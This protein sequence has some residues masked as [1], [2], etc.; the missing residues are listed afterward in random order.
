MVVEALMSIPTIQTSRL[1]LRAF[2]GADAAPLHQIMGEPGVLR[3]FPNQEPPSMDRVARMVASQLAHWQEHG[4]GWWAVQ[5]RAETGLIGWAGLQ[6]LPETDETE[7]AYLLAK[8]YWGQGL[9]TEAARA[10]LDFAF[11]GL[12][13]EQIVGIVHPE[14]AASQGVLEKLGMTLV[15]RTQ[16]FGM[17]CLRYEISKVVTPE[18]A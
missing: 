1:V 17:D 18:S 2:T 12:G 15:E 9:A 13:L 16:Y 3:Y 11:D 8:A 6:Y 10:S 7:V 5:R 14:N 4:Y